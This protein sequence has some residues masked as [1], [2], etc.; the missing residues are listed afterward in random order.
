MAF[1]LENIEPTRTGSLI[2]ASAAER[3]FEVELEA[4]SETTTVMRAV[5]RNQLGVI[6]DGSIAQEI[7]RQ[8]GK[9]LEAETPRRR[10]GN[11]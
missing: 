6:V 5:T 3:R 1:K 10:A 7:I 9:A 11:A 2:K 4:V 8:A